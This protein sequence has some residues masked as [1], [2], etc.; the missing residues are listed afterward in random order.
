MK[1]THFT[2]VLSIT[3]FVLIFTSKVNALN[4]TNPK[5]QITMNVVIYDEQTTQSQNIMNAIEKYWTCTKYK[6]IG[7]DELTEK[8]DSFGSKEYYIFPLPSALSLGVINPCFLIVK[9]S[10][11]LSMRIKKDIKTLKIDPKGIVMWIDHKDLFLYP[12]FCMMQFNNYFKYL[13][14]LNHKERKLLWTKK[15]KNGIRFYKN[16]SSTDLT[17]KTLLIEKSTVTHLFNF[18]KID[19]NTVKSR[20][21]QMLNIPI[22]KIFILEMDEFVN[23][24]ES[25]KEDILYFRHYWAQFYGAPF[26]YLII[27]DHTGQFFICLNRKLKV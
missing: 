23:S 7:I 8:I 20:L 17:G 12:A 27:Y 18:F 4:S 24:F 9:G 15:T 2:I 21:S 1:K 25:G 22:E 10:H 11:Y 14:I 16:V 19:E 6:F 26:L 5:P 3:L 13:F